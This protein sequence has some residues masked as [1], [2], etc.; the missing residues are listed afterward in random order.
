MLSPFA[1]IGSEGYAALGKGRKFIGFEL[2]ES[3]FKHA[4]EFLAA[5]ES[6]GE[7]LFRRGV[8]TPEEMMML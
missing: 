3:Y 1:G 2:K 8:T 7:D 5:A 4:C 6:E